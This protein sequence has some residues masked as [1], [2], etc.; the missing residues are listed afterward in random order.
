MQQIA[1]RHMRIRRPLSKRFDKK[2]AVATMKHPL[3]QMTSGST[4]CCGAAGLFF[5]PLNAT[6]DVSGVA[7]SEA[8][9]AHARPR[10]HDFHAGWRFL[11]P[12]KDGH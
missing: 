2:Y 9:P 6:M 7:Q 8:E 10:I 3:S 5:I 4:S 11:S 12:I 1:P